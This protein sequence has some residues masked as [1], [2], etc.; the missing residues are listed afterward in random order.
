L[1]GKTDPVFSV[2]LAVSVRSEISAFSLRGGEV[3]RLGRAVVDSNIVLVHV[4][5]GRGEKT[6]AE[7]I[8]GC[9]AVDELA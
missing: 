7:C 1:T 8:F 9:E 6:V 3:R 4:L 2:A 5:L